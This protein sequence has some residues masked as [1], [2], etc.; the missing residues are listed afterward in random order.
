MQ[1]TTGGSSF[2]AGWIEKFHGD[3]EADA[4]EE[5]DTG[6]TRPHKKQHYIP[7]TTLILTNADHLHELRPSSERRHPCPLHLMC[8]LLGCHVVNF[9]LPLFMYVASSRVAQRILETQTFEHK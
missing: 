1:R 6:W 4:Q 2:F 5:E 9:S 8:D 7:A 3:A